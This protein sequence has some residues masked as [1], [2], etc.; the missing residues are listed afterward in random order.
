MIEDALIGEIPKP[1]VVEEEV[2]PIDCFIKETNPITIGE[3]DFPLRIST[4][5]VEH[6]L[7]K[8][9]LLDLA[10]RTSEKF[11]SGFCEGECWNIRDRNTHSFMKREAAHLPDA[12]GQE[13]R[14]EATDAEKATV[15]LIAME[16]ELQE[17]DQNWELNPGVRY[18]V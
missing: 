9:F 10:R 14:F 1:Y 13:E 3:C 6:G 4:A 16:A 7:T 15:N 12:P 8:G 2:D 18:R 5:S 17:D 11:E